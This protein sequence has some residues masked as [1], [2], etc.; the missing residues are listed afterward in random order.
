MKRAIALLSLALL[1]GHQGP[2]QA[3][4]PQYVN[5]LASTSTQCNT[6]ANPGNG[7][8]GD[9]AWLAFGKLNL[10][11]A[12]LQPPTPQFGLVFP[13]G[14][15]YASVLPGAV[16]IWCP[17]WSSLTL[18]PTL[19]T[20]PSG[21]GSSA[22]GSLTGGTNTTAAMV[23][24]SGASIAP[25][26][27]GIVDA[28]QANGV[29]F[30]TFATQNYASPPVIGGTAPNVVNATTLNAIAVLQGSLP[31]APLNT[32]QNFQ[33][34]AYTFAATDNGKMVYHAGSGAGSAAA[35]TGPTNSIDSLPIGAVVTILNELGGGTI[36]LTPGDTLI[37]FGGST[38]VCPS[39][40]SS[41]TLA[42]NA[43]GGL[44]M[45]KTGTSQW[46]ER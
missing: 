43:Q 19:V 9:D 21:G 41:T 25:G 10:D 22:F 26:G 15:S 32:P 20:C 2:A 12:A 33:P 38:T 4:A 42:I 23:V 14:V 44:T 13:S 27:T 37:A 36:T 46:F 5:C 3:Q 40:C 34:G 24:G 35:W 31:M 6:I 8:Q 28:N 18:P 17:Q 29:A 45:I 16:G 7:A 39:G 30:G 11:I 1:L